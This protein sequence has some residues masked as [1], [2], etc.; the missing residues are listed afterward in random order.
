VYCLDR[1]EDAY[2]LVLIARV[3][4]EPTVWSVHLRRP[5]AV[6]RGLTVRP[7]EETFDMIVQTIAQPTV[8]R[9]DLTQ[10]PMQLGMHSTI[11][12]VDKTTAVEIL[13][14][15]PYPNQRKVDE[16]TI[17]ILQRA[18]TGGRFRVSTIHLMYSLDTQQW[19]LVN[20]Q[21]RMWANR[22]ADV[23]ILYDVITEIVQSFKEVETA[24][25]AH[26]RGRV[27]SAS[28]LI[29]ALS[30]VGDDLSKPQM[31]KV[32]LA[33]G[34]LLTG[35]GQR[36]SIDRPL[37]TFERRLGLAL[38]LTDEAIGYINATAHRP[39]LQVMKRLDTSV[40]MAFGI[41][42]FWSRPERAAKFW[43]AVTGNAE[44][45]LSDD[46]PEVALVKQVLERDLSSHLMAKQLAACWNAAVDSRPAPRI[47]NRMMA[48]PIQIH[49]TPFDGTTAMRFTIVGDE[50]KVV[51]FD[52]D[53]DA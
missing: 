47:S 17:K 11:A 44:D 38:A 36:R 39:K 5:V 34:V 43:N 27:R 46:A 51:P 22:R 18:M 1:K 14:R 26:D 32:Y 35:F 15:A 19:Y 16:P 23:T 49:S 31:Q 12:Q 2:A 28:Q 25:T 48:A 37:D 33:A 45:E 13:E 10:K 41:A 30:S 3:P 20:G 8:G 24:Y 21:H 53:G 4:S 9:I 29:N 6:C 7:D 42:T 40:V 52:F 50:V